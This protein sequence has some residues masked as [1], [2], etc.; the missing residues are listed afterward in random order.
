[1]KAMVLMVLQMPMH[2]ATLVIIAKP[3]YGT[4]SPKQS[5]SEWKDMLLAARHCLL[6]QNIGSGQQVMANAMYVGMA[7]NLCQ[8]LCKH[9]CAAS[10]KCMLTQQ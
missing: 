3:E 8:P 4:C 5:S 6:Q 1:M 9:N 2:A 10:A 7:D